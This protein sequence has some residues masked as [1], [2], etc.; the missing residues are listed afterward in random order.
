MPQQ[1]LSS[2]QVERFVAK[3]SREQGNKENQAAAAAAR[4]HAGGGATP[5]GKL[6][7]GPARDLHE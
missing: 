4:G 3:L 2:G 5:A 6:G 1:G 7:G